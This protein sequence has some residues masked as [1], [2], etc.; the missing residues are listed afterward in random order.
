MSGAGLQLR[1][2]LLARA[3]TAAETKKAGRGDLPR[4]TPA[5]NTYRILV[6]IIGYDFVAED[7]VFGN[8]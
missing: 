3:A 4:S 6:L 1:V 8:L 7:S 2:S 5:S